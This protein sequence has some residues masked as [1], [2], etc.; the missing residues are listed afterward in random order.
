MN[1][2]PAKRNPMSAT[3]TA[4]KSA[5]IASAALASAAS[6]NSQAEATALDA[7]F[8]AL[9]A[10][11]YGS[12]RASLLPIDQAAVESLKNSAA[13]K[14]LEQRLAAA[15][16]KKISA[17]ASDYICSKLVLIG[18]A[19]AVPAL[20]DL[21][22]SKETAHMALTALQAIPSPASMKAIRARLPKLSGP[23]KA[24]AIHVL[25]MRRDFESVS[26]L[27]ELLEDSNL[28]I[29][30]SA[31]AALGNIATSEAAGALQQFRAKA[32]DSLR[33]VIADSCLA[34]AGQLLKDGKRTESLSLYKTFIAPEHPKHVQLAARRGML[35]A[36][37]A[38]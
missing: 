37:Q 27:T 19:D 4:L 26:I 25:G 23:V 15:L 35:V 34:C 32:P 13:R 16:K 33:P 17:V 20:A 22:G 36:A 9:G 10:Y 38:R 1:N 3:T 11:D 21:L 28:L 7:A 29:A 6:A 5:A 14:E 8:E 2:L 12:A 24:G 30:E 18:S 31:A